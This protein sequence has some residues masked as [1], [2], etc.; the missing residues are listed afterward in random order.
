MILVVTATEGAIPKVYRQVLELSFREKMEKKPL[1]IGVMK[2]KWDPF[3][4]WDP[5]FG[6]G[7]DRTK[8]M[9]ILTYF[10]FK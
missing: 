2:Y 5:F 3:I 10:S 1:L 6:G 9:V 7:V 4:K 8:S